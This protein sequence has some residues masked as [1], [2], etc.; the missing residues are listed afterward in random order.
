M[1]QSWQAGATLVN[2]LSLQFLAPNP[3]QLTYPNKPALALK[4]LRILNAVSNHLRLGTREVGSAPGLFHQEA[5][6][7]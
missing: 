6:S 1:R 5:V 3:C 4:E 2:E 7:L